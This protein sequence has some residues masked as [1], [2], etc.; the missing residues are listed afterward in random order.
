MQADLLRDPAAGDVIPGVE[1][2]RK[3]RVALDGRGKRGGAR[4]IYFYRDTRG[5]IFLLALYPKNKQTDLS[6]DEKKALR[7]IIRQIKEED[8]P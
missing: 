8:Y 2:A 3:L 5:A 1:G 7:S 4:V 6:G